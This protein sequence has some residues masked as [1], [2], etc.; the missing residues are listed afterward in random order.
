M[1]T[2]DTFRVLGP[3]PKPVS[4][5]E[6]LIL[7]SQDFLPYFYLPVRIQYT[8]GDLGYSPVDGFR[9]WCAWLLTSLYQGILSWSYT[10]DFLPYH[11]RTVYFSHLV[12]F[13]SSL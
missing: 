10:K 5:G 13:W 11:Q 12:W 9:V 7:V 1:S 3:V 8:E 2:K 4:S 6:D